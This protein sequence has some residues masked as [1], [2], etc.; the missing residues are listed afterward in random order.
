M[1]HGFE[2]A[3]VDALV[4][5]LNELLASRP[6]RPRTLTV[7]KPAAEQLLIIAR[8]EG[9]EKDVLEVVA[10]DRGGFCLEFRERMPDEAE[11]FG[12]P[13][14]SLRIAASPLTLARIGGATIDFRNERFA[15]D[16]EE[17]KEC[18]GG[19]GCGGECRCASE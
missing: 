2:D 11:A 6:V 14:V 17:K 5:E 16:L 4:V 9:R 3:D 19:G 10:D 15:L 8:G 1:S 18:C 7:T 13:E 12:H